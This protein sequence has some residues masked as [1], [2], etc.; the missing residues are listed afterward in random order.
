[1][2]ESKFLKYFILTICVVALILTLMLQMDMYKN[3]IDL[4]ISSLLLYVCLTYLLHRLALR[5]IKNPDRTKFISLTVVNLSLKMFSSIALLV[6]YFKWTNPPNSNFVHL[7]LVVYIM[8]TI[9]E[10][11][12]LLKVSEE[13]S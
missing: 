10:T 6:I 4:S 2:T 7:F 11:Y 8:F 12:Y 9:F 13:K 5:A 3:Y 1:M